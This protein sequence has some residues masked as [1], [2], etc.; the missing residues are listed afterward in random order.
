VLTG[1]DGL[2]VDQAYL[3]ASV[4]SH[5]DLW[6]STDPCS[7]AAFK[8]ATNLPL[9]R[10]IDW[11][12]P[13]FRRW[14]VWR[15]EQIA[16]Y[17]RAEL[18]TARAVNPEIFLLH[19][20]SSV[21]SGR[22]TYVAADP[23]SLLGVAGA[24]TA[25]EVETIADRMDR[26]ATGM[27]G[28]TLEQWLAFR[29]MIAFAR[30][31]D[32]GK[33]SW[34]LTYG[35]KERDSAQLAGFVLAEGANFYENKGPQMADS[36]GRRWR[37]TLFGWIA[38]HADDFYGVDSVAEVGLLYGPRNRD[39]LDAVAGEPYDAA[40]SIHFAAYRAAA[41]E[42][43]KA[44]V[45]FDVVIDTD[46]EHFAHYRVLI[47]PNLDLMS[48]ATAA[49]LRSFG[50]KL[51]TI[52][53]T[54]KHDE[55]FMARSKPALQGHAQ[56]HFKRVS[57]KAGKAADTGLLKS[58]APAAVQL[59]LRRAADG[60]RLVIINTASAPAP[61]FAVTLRGDR[62][63]AKATAHLSVP[64]QPENSVP[65]T[66]RQSSGTLRVALPAGIETIALITVHLFGTVFPG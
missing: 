53:A 50:G 23:T 25:H 7:V 61:A 52:G 14:I 20:N 8:A 46:I 2:W 43:Y 24:A 4:G 36:V 29:T 26:G 18:Q 37:T 11:D 33:P 54:G 34:V 13:I 66:P 27:Q 1:I 60:Y 49:A 55:W 63:F 44:H 15:H 56:T 39:L 62:A 32:R 22:S 30:A 42:L 47:A 12:D 65:V 59:G 16:E 41:R 38:A 48:D 5:H 10:R 40:D 45:P 17:L 9:P 28:A 51:I 64:A 57:A 21:D 3:Q 6:P 19:E 35:C 31:A 58:T